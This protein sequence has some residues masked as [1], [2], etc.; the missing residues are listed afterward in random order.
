VVY[1]AAPSMISEYVMLAADAMKAP[2]TENPP[3]KR[4]DVAI[5]FLLAPAPRSSILALVGQ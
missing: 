5:S 4:K 1:S 2:I 3:L